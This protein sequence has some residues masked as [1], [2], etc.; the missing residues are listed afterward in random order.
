M[1]LRALS[2]AVSGLQAN[3]TALDVIGDNIANINTPGFKGG[4]ALFADVLSQTVAGAQAPNGNA[5]G[6]DP[7]QIGLGSTVSAVRSNFAQGAVLST[8]NPTDLSIQG[9]GFFV[10]QNGA[11]TFYSRAGAFTLDALGTLV[12]SASGYR[13]QGVAGDVTIPTGSTVPATPTANALFTGNLDASAADGA[14]HVMT[15]TINDSLGAAHTLTL[16][17]TKDYATTP[18]AWNWAVT[19]AD[20][21]IASLTGDTGSLVFDTVGAVSSG[22]TGTLDI[23]YNAAASSA[24]PQTITLDFGSAA[25]GGP[26]TGF[27]ASSTAALN[28]QDGYPAGSLV[29]FSIGPDGSISGNYDNGRNAVIAQL[30][31]ATFSNPGGLMRGG[32]NLWRESVNS[33]TPNVG[34]PG[35]GGRGSLLPGTLEG[36]NVDLAREFTELIQA[37]RGFE[38]NAKMIRVGDEIMQTVVNIR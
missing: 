35:A 6:Q 23:A 14:T 9:E 33:G 5:G 16:T 38:A 26:M 4:R 32:Q 21:A 13:V 19:H 28:T 31:T 22:G 3:Q 1:S 37:Q 29:S 30:E 7:M 27:A 2:T 17:F 20:P 25:N 10:L 8:D 34:V 36:S 18:G 24:T 15:Y 11:E 12:D